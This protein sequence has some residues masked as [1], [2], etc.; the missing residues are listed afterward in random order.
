MKARHARVLITG[1]TGGIGEA[2]SAALVEAGAQV[3][4]CARSLPRLERLAKRLG[5]RTLSVA[6]VD[7]CEADAA[8][9]LAKQA[10]S[11]RINVVIHGAG[12][13]SFGALTDTPGGQLEAVIRTNLI[14]P[15]Q[16]TQ[17]M[18]PQL[19]AQSRA[20][21]MF[22]GS[23]LG[24]IGIPGFSGYCAS[25]FGLY[26]FAE[27]LRRELQSTSVLVQ[28][29]AP[30]ARPSINRPAPP[31]TRPSAS[32]RLRSNCSRAIAPRLIWDASRP[33]LSALMRCWVPGWTPAL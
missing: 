17:A 20:Q 5:N 24:R 14:A 12:I 6:A 3:V 30:R 33:W 13:A 7:L 16:L 4:L 22:I 27:A 31:A 1:A 15:M 9:R 8:Q 32:P 2:I 23:T 26:G 18:L 19:R 25:K 21:L 28:W 10:A 11:H 29:L